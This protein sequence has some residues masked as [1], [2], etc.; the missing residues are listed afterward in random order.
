MNLDL[1]IIII[2]FNSAEV[3]TRCQGELLA[4]GEHPV[5]V[6]DN[7]SPDGSAASLS[8]RFPSAKVIRL[9]T[10]QGYGRAANAGLRLTTTPYALLLN[11]D[12]K[13]SADQIDQLFQH[14]KTD[15]GTTAIWSPATCTEDRAD[16]P[17]QNAL[18]VS[19][20]AML[21][22]VEKIKETGLFDENIFL[23]SEETDLCER[24]I[25]AG[26]SIKFCPDVF[27][28]HLVGQ[29]SGS[30]PEIEHMKWWHFGWSLCY[31]MT[32]HGHCTFWENPQRKYLCYSLYSLL[33]P[34]PTQRKK[35]RAKAAG[36]R[37]FLRGEKAFTTNDMPQ[38]ASS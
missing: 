17:P 28:P 5:F 6:I 26:L 19:G 29:S 27:F 30:S 4:S 12:L 7:A 38:R 2:S 37:A 10:N 8:A 15:T 23:F 18:W 35:C 33:T 25:Q 16:L 32:K 14:T 24:A 13:V 20:S 11:P 36:C 31:Q 21:F 3:I 22:D 9:E 34:S 1:T